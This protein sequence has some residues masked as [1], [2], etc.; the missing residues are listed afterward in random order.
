MESKEEPVRMKTRATA[1]TG[2]HNTVK[3]VEDSTKET[4]NTGL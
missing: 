2:K 3:L 4:C 1:L